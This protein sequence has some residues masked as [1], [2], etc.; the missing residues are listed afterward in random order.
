MTTVSG[1]VTDE[2]KEYTNW[3]KFDNS[4]GWA[5]YKLLSSTTLSL[6]PKNMY[7]ET[8]V[9]V[10]LFIIKL[11]ISN[12]IINKTIIYKGGE[13]IVLEQENVTVKLSEKK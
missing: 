6:N 12:K 5:Y 1:Y 10:Y 4:N 2:R 9:D 11:P 13:I 8:T 3:L 7:E